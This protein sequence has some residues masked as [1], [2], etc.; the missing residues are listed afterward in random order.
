[1]AEL[2]YKCPCCDGSIEFDTKSQNMK[3]PYC[4]TEFPVE[5]L[6]AYDSEL[7]NDIPEDMSWNTDPGAEWSDGEDAVLRSYVCESCGGEIVCDETTAATSCPF[8][9]NHVI[10]VSNFSG[11]LKPDYVIP[12]KYDKNAAKEAL[13]KH[14]MGKKLLPKVFKDENHIDEVKGIYV[15]V[16]LFDADADADIRCKGTIIRTWQDSRNIYTETNYYSVLRGGNISFASVPVDGSMKMDDTLME[17]IEPFNFNEAV[18]FRTAYLSGF[19][20]D[21]YDVTAEESITR[22]NDRIKRTTEDAFRSTFDGYSTVVQQSS[23]IR[24]NNGKAKYA[25]YPVWLLSTTWKDK[26][27]IFAMNGQ[28]GKFAGDLTLDKSAYNKW[29]F[30]LTGD[31]TAIAYGLCWLLWIM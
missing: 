26:K 27:Y 22:A 17:S 9:G 25:L 5:T 10:M 4:D 2:Q 3:C 1:M 6:E 21:K 29:L 12:F 28:T 20:A 18:D 31:I 13:R 23:S 8:C 16:W 24:L 11:M 7:K 15:P 30:G 14:Y 19:L